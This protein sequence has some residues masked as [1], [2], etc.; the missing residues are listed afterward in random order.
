VSSSSS[1]TIRR[2]RRCRRRIC[3]SSPIY[4][5]LVLADAQA[6]LSFLVDLGK[7]PTPLLFLDSIFG[8]TRSRYSLVRND[9]TY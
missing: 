2:H 1:L 5:T 3:P 4:S 7:S 9:S 6:R 8:A